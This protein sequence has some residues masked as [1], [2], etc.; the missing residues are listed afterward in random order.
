[1]SIAADAALSS[2]VAET[3]PDATRTAASATRELLG[4]PWVELDTGALV[5]A[6]LATMWNRELLRGDA[7]LA[8]SFETKRDVVLSTGAGSRRG[9]IKRYMEGIWRISL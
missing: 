5:D 9:P 6:G 7:S 8:D 1:M 3:T 2:A 4:R